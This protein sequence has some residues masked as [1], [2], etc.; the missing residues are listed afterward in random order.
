MVPIKEAINSGAWL[1]CE[2]K[3]GYNTYQFRVKVDS[4]KI[5]NLKEVDDPEEIDGLDENSKLYMLGIEVIN[6]TKEPVALHS[7]I[8]FLLLVDQDGFKF[9][10]F[11]ERH[12]YRVSEFGKKHKLQRFDFKELLPKIKAVGSILFQ[13]PDDDE[14]EYFI[15][16]Q[17]DGTV[18]EV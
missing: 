9:P 4:F 2:H 3:Y 11:K 1:H 14:A 5:L 8:D 15:S 16:I 7:S 17:N 12:L 18:Q 10:I 13:L 6:I